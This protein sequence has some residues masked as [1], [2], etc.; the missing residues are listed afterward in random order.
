M[1][2]KSEESPLVLI[3]DLET[4]GLDPKEN[5]V[6]EAAWALWEPQ[7]DRIVSIESTRVAQPE[8]KR[9]QYSDEIERITGIP[10]EELGFGRDFQEVQASL[11]VDLA[12]SSFI[13]GHNLEFDLS[14]L[15]TLRGY[16]R[17]ILKIDTVS[18][19]PLS[20]AL[21]SR[22]LES[23]CNWHNIRRPFGS[24]RAVFDVMS[25]L[26]VVRLYNW[27]LVVERA[28]SPLVEV[29]AVL[30]FNEM[31]AMAEKDRPKAHGFYWDA[32]RKVW[33]RKILQC[34]LT[35]EGFPFKIRKELL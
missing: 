21:K 11:M 19:L 31:N 25:L 8:L 3:V 12:R 5:V 14:F 10:F 4:S 20:S 1:G 26:Q 13:L 30:S 7:S 18:A 16:K 22:S 24:H 9:E 23:I 15:T 6:T 29:F 28:R 34:D 32:T 35:P 27:D 33:A 17:E 2:F